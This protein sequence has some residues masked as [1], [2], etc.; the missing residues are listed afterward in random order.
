MKDYESRFLRG[1]HNRVLGPREIKLRKLRP[2]SPC[3][4]KTN[5]ELHPTSTDFCSNRVR[6]A[7]LDAHLH[8]ICILDCKFFQSN[9][10]DSI[11]N[12]FPVLTHVLAMNWSFNVYFVNCAEQNS[13]CSIKQKHFAAESK[14]SRWPAIRCLA[15]PYHTTSA[16]TV[17]TSSERLIAGPLNS[18]FPMRCIFTNQYQTKYNSLNG[19]R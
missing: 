6:H 4:G 17:C 19:L 16:Y 7:V 9:L 13:F 3:S 14:T 5:W 11:E 10:I 18:A 8:S 2:L 12:W 1:S 15:L